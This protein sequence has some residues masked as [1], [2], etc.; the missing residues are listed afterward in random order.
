MDGTK[1]DYELTMLEA[2]ECLKNKRAFILQREQE[3]NQ[4]LMSCKADKE[5]LRRDEVIRILKYIELKN[6]APRPLNVQ[7]IDILVKHCQR[8][9]K[10]EIDNTYIDFSLLK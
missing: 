6:M 3:A 10:G 8:K 9:L 7:S 5:E 2:N 4:L 1:Y